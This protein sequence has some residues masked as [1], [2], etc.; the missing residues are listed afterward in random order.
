[1]KTVYLAMSVDLI[2]P[3]HINIIQKAANL[4]SLTI[5]VLSDSA[6]A[7]YKKIPHMSFDQK[8]H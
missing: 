8:S 3:G 2:H 6:I 1:M 4:G 5:G 7:S